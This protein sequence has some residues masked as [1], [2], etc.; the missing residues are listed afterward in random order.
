MTL[1]SGVGLGS[2]WCCTA[3]TAQLSSATRSF[4]NTIMWVEPPNSKWPISTP[5]VRGTGGSPGADQEL[6]VD[7]AGRDLDHAEA[8]QGDIAAGRVFE[9][10][11]C[12][13]R[14]VAE[15]GLRLRP[16]PR[17]PAALDISRPHRH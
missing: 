8:D 9:D 12:P 1:P 11:D 15:I 2:F 4:W 16:L 14:D 5:R 3:L 13:R 17:A 6:R 7:D 10:E